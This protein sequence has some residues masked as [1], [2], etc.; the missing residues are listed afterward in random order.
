M[1]SIDEALDYL[2]ESVS[3]DQILDKWR[4]KG[5][6]VFV[7]ESGDV[8]TVQSLIVPRGARK[9]GTGTQVMQELVAYADEVGKRMEVSP[10]LKDPYHGTTSHGRLIKFYKGFGF[11]RNRGRS[12]D[13]SLSSTMYRPVGG[14]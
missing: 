14:S 12:K 7:I 2:L 9:Q 6:T 4:D 13:Y 1:V 5:I 11:V 10:G 8:I 3:L